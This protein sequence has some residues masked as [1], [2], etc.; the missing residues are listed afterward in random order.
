MAPE[1]VKVG[2]QLPAKAPALASRL[3]S[4]S[5]TLW[6][7]PSVVDPVQGMENWP[8]PPELGISMVSVVLLP[9]VEN[10]LVIGPLAPLELHVA[11]ALCT[12][13]P[14]PVPEVVQRSCAEPVRGSVA[15][16]M[17]MVIPL[18]NR[19]WP[20]GPAVQLPGKKLVYP[21]VCTQAS[22]LSLKRSVS[23]AVP[24]LPFSHSSC[25][26]SQPVATAVQ[27]LAVS[28][29]TPESHWKSALPLYPACW[30]GVVKVSRW[31][32]SMPD[33]APKQLPQ[34]WNGWAAQGAWI[35]FAEHVEVTGAH[36]PSAWHRPVYEPEEVAMVLLTVYNP[37]LTGLAGMLPPQIA[38]LV[39]VHVL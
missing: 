28:F 12:Q 31:A 34:V 39:P 20:E 13:T 14:I 38:P 35:V 3:A 24:V 23:E 17:E 8:L 33:P 1:G 5:T 19:H 30:L 6:C 10:Q 4:V 22:L 7:E 18:G 9:A 15:S 32:F 11:A 37:G 16:W 27:V 36:V 26:P 21:K 2:A 29:Q 25:A